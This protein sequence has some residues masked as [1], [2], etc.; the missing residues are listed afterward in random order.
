[1][2]LQATTLSRGWQFKES[3]DDS[4]TKETWM[5]VPAVPSVV[6]QDL[7]ANKRYVTEW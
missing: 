5:P 7:Q 1:M 2:L 6:H 3:N 4:E